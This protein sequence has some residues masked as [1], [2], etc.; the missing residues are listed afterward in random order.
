VAPLKSA[1]MAKYMKKNVPGM[2]V[3]DA[4]ISH[5]E[6]KKSKTEGIDICVEIIGKLRQ[7]EGL[8]GIHIMAIEWEDVVAQLVERAGLRTR[9]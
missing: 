2:D 7:I 4:I 8:S 1:G 9:G 6:Q 3:P 5:L